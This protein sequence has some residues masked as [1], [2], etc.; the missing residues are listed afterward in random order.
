[1]RI[2]IYN[3]YWSTRGGGER[4]AATLAATLAKNQEVELI[5]VE[6]I[7]P[8]ELGEHL[9]IDL[10]RTTFRRWPGIDEARLAPRS[11][12]YDLFVNSTFSSTLASQARRSAYVVFFPQKVAGG[13][14]LDPWLRTLRR[15]EPSLRS[16]IVPQG[17][18]HSEE[19]GRAWT[20]ERAE[21]LVFPRAFQGRT[22]RILFANPP[23]HPA[24]EML[25]DV[26]CEGL[27]W[28]IED[29]T[30]VLT[31]PRKPRSPV[32]VTLS[33]RTFVPR[34]SGLTNDP[35]QLG[36]CIQ[37][38]TSRARR[39]AGSF[40]TRMVRA[41]AR[42]DSAFLETYDLALSISEFTSRW[43]RRRWGLRDEVLAPPVDIEAFRCEDP[44]E[45]RP[46]ILA[47][48]RFFHGSHN[49]K[50]V[51][52]ARVFRRMCDRGEVPRGWELRL[53]G[54]VHRNRLE[55]LEHYADVERLARGYPIRLLPDLPFD[56]LRD[57]YRKAS[58]FW[59]A[60]GWGESERRHPEKLEHFGLTTCEAMSAGA[61]PVVIAKAGQLE[62][63][64]DGESGFLFRN[65]REL[66]AITTS[67]MSELGTGRLAERSRL[68]MNEVR[69]FSQSTFETQLEE[70]LDR[71]GLLES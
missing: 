4:Y 49:K 63:V 34:Q 24:G 31:A 15:L 38:T 22:A 48:G 69:R 58:I 32:P 41:S 52:M 20:R 53:A 8:E 33:S 40:L 39:A 46:V 26:E 18:F 35:R 1:M 36:L 57:E 67:L 68:A 23:S 43:V 51:E 27:T 44:R 19:G 50:H 56:S 7:D 60:A 11:A 12:D 61:V 29:D 59:H 37:F 45:K 3:R 62:I 5:G 42:W 54:T 71:H 21:M 2:G 16:P 6:S 13:G 30:L 25:E 55:D 64:R 47:V 66:A 70:I 9:G 10:S 14:L 28:A 65:G 17:G